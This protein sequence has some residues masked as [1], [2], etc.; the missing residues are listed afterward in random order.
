VDR[1]AE[2]QDSGKGWPRPFP[3]QKGEYGSRKPK[4]EPRQKWTQRQIHKEMNKGNAKPPGLYA[5]INKR[6]KAGTSRSKKNST[7]SKSAYANMK[8]GFPKKK[9]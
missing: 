4:A 8:A 6:R 9:K 2:A 5:N 3:Y 1:T 7:V